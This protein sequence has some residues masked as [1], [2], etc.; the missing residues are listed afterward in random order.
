MQATPARK[1][2]NILN[3]FLEQINSKLKLT[4]Q[5]IRILNFW[6]ILSYFMR[7]IGWPKFFLKPHKQWHFEIISNLTHFFS[8]QDTLRNLMKLLKDSS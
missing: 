3:C 8:K 2:W 1:F 4:K 7:G 6:I 5:T